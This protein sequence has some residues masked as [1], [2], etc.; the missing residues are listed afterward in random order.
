MRNR[1]TTSATFTVLIGLATVA[2]LLQ[3]LWAG[4]FIGD[5]AQGKSAGG[6]IDIHARGGRWHSVSPR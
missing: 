2:V 1:R 3:G 5:D 6:W 4:I